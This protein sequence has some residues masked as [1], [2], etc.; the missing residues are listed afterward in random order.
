MFLSRKKADLEIKAAVE[1]AL[2]FTLARIPDLGPIVDDLHGQ[3]TALKTELRDYRA[4]Q[5][6]HAT[7]MVREVELRLQ[8]ERALHDAAA[9]TLM[10]AVETLGKEVQSIPVPTA[11]EPDARIPALV[12]ELRT[13][14]EILHREVDELTDTVQ[15]L[16]DAPASS[17]TVIR[18]IREEVGVRAAY[19][20]H[21][22][23]PLSVR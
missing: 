23:R 20:Q 3:V 2:E 12:V 22:V 4:D 13:A 6:E 11:P 8:G 18:E 5:A 14:R 15:Y 1:T 16:W 9:T 21:T 10:Q 19:D 7:E 17:T